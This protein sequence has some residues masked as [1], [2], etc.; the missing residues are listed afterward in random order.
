MK[1]LL[2]LISCVFV[3]GSVF[4][5]Q[6]R[7]NPSTGTYLAE[8]E[9]IQCS[10]ETNQYGQ[11]RGCICADGFFYN[12]KLGVCREEVRDLRPIKQPIAQEETTPESTEES[13]ADTP[14]NQVV[15][16]CYKS[17]RS[18]GT[19]C[20]CSD[21]AYEFDIKAGACVRAQED[22]EEVAEAE[23]QALEDS[24]T[25]VTT[26]IPG[27]VNGRMTGDGQMII[28]ENGP[29]FRRTASTQEDLSR[30][31][32]EQIEERLQDTDL[33]VGDD[34]YAQPHASQQ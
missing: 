14:E 30:V 5:D 10:R 1:K 17:H 23:E 19:N 4:A 24:D 33:N 22:S 11:R 7:V 9:P 21:P 26:G 15:F 12:P 16:R 2:F 29:R 27:C 34:Y 8:Q 31:L 13:E 6:Q 3:V 20:R 25:V 18:V 32:A 28:C